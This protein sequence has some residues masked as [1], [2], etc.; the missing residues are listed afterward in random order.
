MSFFILL[1]LFFPPQLSS[2]TKNAIDTFISEPITYLWFI[3]PLFGLM[4]IV[5]LIMYYG[6][7]FFASFGRGY[8]TK[9]PYN[10]NI[11]ILIASKNEKQL[12]ERT[13]N[14]IIESNYPKEN[15]Q[16]II[17]AS[18]STDGTIEFCN[19]L[20]KNHTQIETSKS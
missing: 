20:A 18:G 10:A 17:V 1:H 9:A 14:S 11:S 8:R 13:L 5:I 12:L 16:L 3:F 15:I 2:I 6:R 19:N 7:Y 4:I